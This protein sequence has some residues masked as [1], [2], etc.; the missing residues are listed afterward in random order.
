[1]LCVSYSAH[2]YTLS[3]ISVLGVKRQGEMFTFLA[4]L[5]CK[6]YHSQNQNLIPLLWFKLAPM[7]NTIYK[8]Y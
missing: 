1:M 4:T 7:I 2:I 6:L 5:P 8:S 3:L